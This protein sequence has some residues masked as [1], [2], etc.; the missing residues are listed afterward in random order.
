MEYVAVD[1]YKG[2]WERLDPQVSA[3]KLE[4]V[5]QVYGETEGGQQLNKTEIKSISNPEN[6][7]HYQHTPSWVGTYTLVNDVYRHA[8][9]TTAYL[10]RGTT[11]WSFSVNIC[12]GG[13]WGI[14]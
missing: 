11:T 9:R 1:Y 10:K 2:K 8:G 7:T 4:I 13:T 12:A 6:N 5:A 14:C 3:T